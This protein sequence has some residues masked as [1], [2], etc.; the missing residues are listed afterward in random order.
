MPRLRDRRRWHPLTITVG[1][2][3]VCWIAG[4]IYLWLRDKKAEAVSYHDSQINKEG[5][6]SGDYGPDRDH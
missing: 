3:A 1:V 6:F 5:V 2:L 4:A